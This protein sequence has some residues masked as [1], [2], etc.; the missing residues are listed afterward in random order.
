[1]AFVMLCCLTSPPS[2]LCQFFL[3]W[4]DHVVV[5]TTDHKCSPTMRPIPDEA[6]SDRQAFHAMLATALRSL[7]LPCYPAV[8]RR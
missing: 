2:I 1:M 5:G 4:K 6:V 7:L 3:P 8:S